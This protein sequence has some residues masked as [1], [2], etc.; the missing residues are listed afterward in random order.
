MTKR[1]KGCGAYLQS[2]NQEEIGYTPKKN[3]E[4]CQRCFRITHYDDVTISMKQG[5]DSKEVLKNIQALSACILWVVDLFDF[6][7]NIVEDMAHYFMD[8]NIIMVVSKRDLLPITLSDE[9]LINFIFNRL[10]HYQ[11]HVHA[12]VISGDLVKNA[13]AS[14]NDSIIHVEE[15]ITRYRNHQ[16][17]VVM[18]VANAGKSTL[19]N[20]LIHEHNS[21]TTSHHPGTTLE[22]YPVYEGLYKI[23]DSPGIT[24]YDSLLT[25][26][27]ETLLKKVIPSKAIKPQI[28]QLTENQTLSLAGFARIDLLGCKKV[29]A[30]CYVSEQLSVHRTNQRNADKL[31]NI[32]LNELL[33]PSLN[34]SFND[35]IKHTFTKHVDEKI[36][37][38]IHGLGWICISGDVEKIDVYID[39][40]IK[41]TKREAI[42]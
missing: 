26:L 40:R 41:I 24:R 23:Y 18:G 2:T 27:D 35:M 10:T 42:L 16:D 29:S 19:L 14:F 38:V 6:E 20:A 33:S 36:D 3:S 39:K 8:K 15:A 1:C 25:Y 37:L 21:I 34:N 30:V 12:I 22:I 7:A 11:I 9:K 32:H 28:Y 17:I 4:Y 13:Y 31:W 5:I